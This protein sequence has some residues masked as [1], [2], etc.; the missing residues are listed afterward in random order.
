[1]LR[2]VQQLGGNKT[3]AAA[4]LGIDR[5]TLYRRLQLYEA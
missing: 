4:L 3:R 1:V 2:V 5:R